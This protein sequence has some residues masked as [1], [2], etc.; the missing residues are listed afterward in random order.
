MKRRV[1]VP[2]FSYAERKVKLPAA[3]FKNASRD[4]RWSNDQ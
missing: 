1:N 2:A 3:L 4:R